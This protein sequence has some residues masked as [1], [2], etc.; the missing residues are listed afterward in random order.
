MHLERIEISG[1]RGIKRLSLTFDE[2][3]VLIGENAWG[4][5]SLLDALSIALS[6]DAQFYN[7]KFSDFHV[8]YTLGNKKMTQLQIILHWKEDAEGEHIARRYKGFERFWVLKHNIR[9]L[10][11]QIESVI[12]NDKVITYRR[13]LNHHGREIHCDE[14][15]RMIKR[16]MVLHPVVRLRDARRLRYYDDE[17]K[18]LHDSNDHEQL[19]TN[20][21]SDNHVN[22]NAQQEARIQKRLDNTCRRLMTQPGHV[23]SGELKSS[24]KALHSLV[25]HYFAFAPHQ[26]Q[27][28]FNR[29]HFPSFAQY[30]E[31]P[32]EQLIPKNLSKQN[33]LV[34]LGLLNAFIRARGPVSLKRLSRPILIVEDPEGR[35]HPTILQQAWSFIS[36]M[37]MQKILTT[38]S[39]ELLSSVPL[40]SIKKLIRQADRTQ[41]FEVGKRTLG[42][43]ETRRVSFHV[44]LHRPSALFAR[45]WLLVEGETEVWLFNE[46]A[47]YCGYNLAAEGVQIIEFAQSG[48]RPLVKIARSLGIEWHLISDGDMAGRKYAETVRNMLG[49][50]AERHRLT[51]LPD[52]DIEHYLYNQGYEALF[53]Q[54]SG[55]QGDAPINA[56]KIIQRALKRH[57]KPDVALAIVE[58]THEG[59]VDEVPLLIRWLLKR[60][61][62]MSRGVS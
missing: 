19:Q 48:L 29:A 37:P 62:A 49:T 9:H 16:W 51:V 13:F 47:R 45:A 60:I 24:I 41:V 25:D 53:K 61:V 27:R 50:D 54:L 58:Y 18:P 4:K 34:L 2:L 28:N 43:D 14:N 5:S 42:K 55:I 32:F 22:G 17:N 6:P 40:Q 52:R 20:G 1:F 39:P 10:Y 3:S 57:A 26:R 59:K 7:F 36:S 23:N 11:Y 44:R 56:H 21:H 15:D 31:H 38:N 30:A 35:L 8:D 12:E 46:L 33:Q